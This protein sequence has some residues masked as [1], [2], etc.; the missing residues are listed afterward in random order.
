M[1]PAQ[2]RTRGAE[3]Y[4][5]A[6]PIGGCV[7]VADAR[8]AAAVAVAR[9]VAAGAGDGAVGETACGTVSAS[10]AQA[11][12]ST[13]AGERDGDMPG[14]RGAAAGAVEGG[15]IVP[16]AGRATPIPL[17]VGVPW[18]GGV[19]AGLAP[20]PCRTRAMTMIASNATNRITSPARA[21]PFIG[22][23]RGGY[24]GA[25]CIVCNSDMDLDAVRLA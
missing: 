14:E 24:S 19:P 11:W 20:K 21:H 16:V 6:V 7:G 10:A 1:A 3:G 25:S 9:L 22:G 13:G 4:G 18:R 5:V 8:G 12:R 2:R 15:G 17:V 23:C